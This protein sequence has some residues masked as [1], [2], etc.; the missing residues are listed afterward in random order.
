MHPDWHPWDS[1]VVDTRTPYRN[2]GIP[3]YRY[4]Y[5]EES[6]IRISQLFALVLRTHTSRT[7]H[8]SPRDHNTPV[9]STGSA[10]YRC[11]SVDFQVS[12][13]AS[14]RTSPYTPRTLLHS[15]MSAFVFICKVVEKYMCA[16]LRVR[17]SRRCQYRTTRVAQSLGN[18]P[19]KPPRKVRKVRGLPH[20]VRIL[21][22]R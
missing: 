7:T 2:R 16:I 3:E 19:R 13:T 6:R 4:M 1:A 12:G 9:R 5:K 18:V 20:P 17:N 11:S 8:T 10:P 15:R 22:A 21:E 14:W